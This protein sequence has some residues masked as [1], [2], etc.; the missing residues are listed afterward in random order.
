MPQKKTDSPDA[1][2]LR[3]RAQKRLP[4]GHDRP[5][6]GEPQMAPE[7]QRLVCELQMHQIELE[8][9]NEEVQ[10]ARAEAE[11]ALSRYTDLY[12]LA[13][14]GYLT[15]GRGGEI[16][17]LNLT[18][19]RLLGLE[20]ARLVRRRLGPLLATESRPIF[21]AFVSTMF[22]GSA[23]ATCEVVLDARSAAT[24][25]LELNGTA[26][27]GREECRVVVT[28]VTERHRAA[29]ER[30]G[31]QSQLAQAQ[32]MEAIGTLAGGIAHDFNNILGGVLGT[33]SL[34]DHEG[35]EDGAHHG[36]FRDMMAMVNRGVD[37]TKQLLGFARRGKYDVRPL[38]LAQ[39]VAKTS[40]MFGRTRSDITIRLETASGLYPVLMDHTQLEQVLLNLF[41]NAGQAMPDGGSL[42]VRASDVELVA[43]DVA[44]HD[45]APGRFAKLSVLDTGVGMDPPTQARIFEPFFT[46]KGPGHGTGLGLASVYG[47][48]KNHGGFVTVESTLGRGSTFDLFLP[49]TDPLPVAA[50]IRMAPIRRGT[51]TILVVDDEEMIVKVV[52]RLLRSIG[53]EVLSA[54][55]GKQ[56][57]ELL[58]SH[59]G[60]ISLVILDMIMPEMSGRQTYDALQEIAPGIKVLLSTGYSING[61]AQEMLARGCNGFIQKP[62]DAAALSEKL[63]EIL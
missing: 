30:E 5:N 27:E 13:P 4:A 47:I 60:T 23:K 16:R 39:V 1:H 58:R 35:G 36:D 11:E 6:S 18:G 12:E 48:V 10:R 17:Q 54:T 34:L 32:K 45:I 3:R 29:H 52:S 8:L 40:S 50:T 9:Q 55:G 61:Q 15:L 46:T 51:E 33:L 49:S 25:T 31:L 20:R 37:L 62:F 21:D 43:A 28:D 42:L 56:A 57:V 7:T 2:A 19:A 22:G 59:R 41:V 26:V 63:R 53:Y 38:D 44:P 14:V 24:L